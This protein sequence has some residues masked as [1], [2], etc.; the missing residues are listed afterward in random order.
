VLG[1]PVHPLGTVGQRQKG[2]RE[3]RGGGDRSAV[4]F[5]YRLR[6]KMLLEF[7][8]AWAKAGKSEGIGIRSMWITGYVKV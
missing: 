1:E 8:Q 4:V 3:K 2:K 7:F 6:K 5:S